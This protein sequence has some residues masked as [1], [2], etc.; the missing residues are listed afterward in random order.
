MVINKGEVPMNLG[1]VLIEAAKDGNMLVL[2]TAL[3]KGAE[4][5]Q[6]MVP[7]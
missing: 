5:M 7:E 6:K 2:K 4:S 3:E 1:Q